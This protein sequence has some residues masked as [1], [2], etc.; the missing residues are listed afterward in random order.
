[1]KAST[2]FHLVAAAYYLTVMYYEHMQTRKIPGYNT[3]GG[4]YKFLT[5]IN[6]VLQTVFF[7][8]SLVADLASKPSRGRGKSKPHELG[9]IER[10]RDY[11]YAS[12]AFPVA[13]FISVMFWSLYFID[14]EL[15][16]P[17]F[18]DEVVPPFTNLVQ[19]LFISFWIVVDGVLTCHRYP[20]TK[21]A[22]AGVSLFGLCYMA[23]VFW[24]ANH[25]K[26]WIYPVLAVLSTV[27]RVLF[28]VLCFGMIF[29]FF[30]LG[31]WLHNLRWTSRCNEKKTH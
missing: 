31:R 21:D 20:Y 15:I 5:Q 19:H 27:Q 28:F 11:L 4:R 8:L 7:V 10:I 22:L 13:T 16:Y 12:L 6:M 30:F 29:L 2:V 3:Y 14:R 24:V 18:L 17:K 9:R 23:W 1:M 25:A 26:F